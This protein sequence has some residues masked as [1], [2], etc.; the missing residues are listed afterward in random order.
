VQRS[1][2]SLVNKGGQGPQPNEGDDGGTL[3]LARCSAVHR[4]G[5]R[6]P[7]S[8]NEAGRKAVNFTRGIIQCS[9]HL[10]LNN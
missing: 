8:I 6:V 3:F 2:W 9:N 10:V 1:R 5:G 7:A 4:I